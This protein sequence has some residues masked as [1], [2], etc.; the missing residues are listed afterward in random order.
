ME[1]RGTRDGWQSYTNSVLCVTSEWRD[2]EEAEEEEGSRMVFL[3]QVREAE[4]G[5][6]SATLLALRDEGQEE[7]I[8]PRMGG[9]GQGESGDKND[10]LPL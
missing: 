7:Q 6:C 2:S 8:Q 3:G 5:C 4:L 10:E 1:V 9:W